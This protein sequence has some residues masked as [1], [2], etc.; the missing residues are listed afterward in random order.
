MYRCALAALCGT[1]LVLGGRADSPRPADP[2]RDDGAHRARLEVAAATNEPWKVAVAVDRP[3]RTYEIGEVVQI[4]VTSEQAGY[5]YLFSVDGAGKITCLFPNQYQKKNEI[6]A[7]TEVTVPAPEEK[8]FRLRAA[9]PA[10]K[11]MIKAVVTKQ[12]SE[13]M[14][15]ED[16]TRAPATRVPANKFVRLVVEAM[17]G[18]PNKVPDNPPEAQGTKPQVAV[19]KEKIQEEKPQQ[20]QQKMKE[21]ATGGVEITLIEAKGKPTQSQDKP[22]QDKPKPPEE[23]PSQDKPKP[24]KPKPDKPKPPEDKPTQS[25]DRPVQSQDQPKR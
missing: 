21:W 16:F 11:E 17:G 7:N 24:D 14:R 5:L 2:R 20:F 15:L 19:Q 12:P 13:E 9:P 4:K 22:T 3:E 25:Q 6:Q 23:K 10:G 8:G 18:D 1:T